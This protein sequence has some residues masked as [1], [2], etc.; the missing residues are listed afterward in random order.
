MEG[1]DNAVGNVE[2]QAPITTVETT[3]GTSA[4][5]EQTT[6]NESLNSP[7]VES[8][9]QDTEDAGAVDPLVGKTVP[10]SRFSEI[11][12]KNK[13]LE[14]KLSQ[15]PQQGQF[16]PVGNESE[17]QVKTALEKLGYVDKSTVEQ[18][19]QE[20]IA[21]DRVYREMDSKVQQLSKEWD[22]KDGKPAFNIEEVA[23]YAQ[24]TGIYDPEAAFK[25]MNAQGL[26]EF[27]AK[28]A[29]SNVKTERQGKPI[30]NVG[31]D[32]G[33]MKEEAIK[34]NDFSSLIKMKLNR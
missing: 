22:G 19:V 3:T 24:K 29:R 18:L 11:Y 7:E 17:V 34:N 4:S 25:Q 12:N 14:A 21:G 16:A 13:E 15:V 31:A 20:A 30:Q 32:Y 23:E 26:A 6:S 10:Y 33:A 5:A 28:Q 9:T 27:Y 8:N 1:Q 2:F